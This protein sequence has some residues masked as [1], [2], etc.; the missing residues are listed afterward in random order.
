MAGKLLYEV[1]Q[2]SISEL[3]N[4]VYFRLNGVEDKTLKI[5]GL[6]LI[7]V[8]AYTSFLILLIIKMVVFTLIL[9]MSFV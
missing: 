2:E 8:R 4:V 1:I 9:P 7:H 6:K 5:D 3:A